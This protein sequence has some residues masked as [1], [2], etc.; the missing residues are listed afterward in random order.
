MRLTDDLSA[1][2]NIEECENILTDFSEKTTSIFWLEDEYGNL[3]YPVDTSEETEIFYSDRTITF[4]EDMPP[5][6][7]SSVGKYTNYYP[8]ILKDGST[9]TL[10]V[11]VDLYVVH[12]TTAVLWSIFPY[13]LV[14]IFLLSLLCSW[15]YAKYITRPIVQLS[16]ASK[17]I[18]ALDFSGKCDEKRED[19]LGCLAQNLN[20]LSTALSA[21][22]SELQDV[23]RQLK[24]DIEREQ[25]LE[26]Q[27][28][29]FF[30][31]ASHELKT[32]LTILKGH[33]TGML[34]N[35]SGYEDHTAYM[36]RSLAVVDKMELLV[37]ELLYVSRSDSSKNNS[38]YEVV[39]I[40]EIFRVQIAGVTDLLMDKAQQLDVNIP[41]KLFCQVERAQM[42]RAIQN[43]LVNA[44]RYSP[45]GEW[46]KIT[47]LDEK[48][49]ISCQVENTGTHIPENAI[50]HLFE[51]FYRADNSHNRITGGTGLG[52]YI[53][54]KI[55]D[56]HHAQYGI[57]NTTE[58]VL[59]SF[60]LPK[61]QQYCNSI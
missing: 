36:E 38:E 28:I 34:N 2:N 57:T 7:A 48:D 11:Q 14:M 15:F 8:V 24:T 13:V 53:V 61:K 40:A 45:N 21:A 31:A 52:L 18:A 17:K 4:D 9:Y 30:A 60:T 37:K 42:E 43:I 50:E 35:I 20:Y 26:R 6:E 49:F 58:G 32:P 33:L 10:A 12:Q 16:R 54:K 5:V 59:F 51:A 29:D 44:I 19:E 27:R 22:M 1:Y 23:N 41:D 55:M 56:R 25:E 3:V 39:N 46:L 47:L